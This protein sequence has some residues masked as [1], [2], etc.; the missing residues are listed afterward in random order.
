MANHFANS[1]KEVSNTKILGISS[2]NLERLKK[3]GDKFN[4]KEKYRFNSY[5]DILK[6]D[7]I[8]SIYNSNQYS[9]FYL[10]RIHRR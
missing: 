4:I 8:N 2:L 1:I 7:E 5:E 3:F 9:I 6:C 10:C